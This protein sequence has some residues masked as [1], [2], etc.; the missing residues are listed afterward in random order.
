MR[1][2]SV[3]NSFLSI[4]Q[5]LNL[6]THRILSESRLC[7]AGSMVLNPSTPMVLPPINVLNFR[8]NAKFS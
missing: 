1:A 5:I 7:K 4:F 8:T 6:P 3:P 2:P